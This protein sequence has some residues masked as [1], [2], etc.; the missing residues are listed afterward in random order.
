M[1]IS[2]HPHKQIY[3]L[4]GILV[5][6]AC[7]QNFHEIFSCGRIYQNCVKH[8]IFRRSSFGSFWF[9]RQI[10]TK[11]ICVCTMFLITTSRDQ[12]YVR[13]LPHNSQ[14]NRQQFRSLWLVS[15]IMKANC[16]HRNVPLFG[17]MLRIFVFSELKLSFVAI[18]PF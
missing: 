11:I 8:H 13:P 4:D 1:H 12:T 9:Q 6:C 15:D 17:H 18:K 3:Y 10:V 5:L 7:M 16:D 2:S 14:Y